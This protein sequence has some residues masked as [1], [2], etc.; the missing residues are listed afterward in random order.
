MFIGGLRGPTEF[1]SNLRNPDRLAR[2]FAEHSKLAPVHSLTPPTVTIRADLS[3]LSHATHESP[4]IRSACKLGEVTDDN[5][6]RACKRVQPSAV[7]PAL[8]IQLPA[9]C[10]PYA[11][12]GSLFG[13]H[14]VTS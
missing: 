12:S 5:R 9:R 3:Y 10:A 6:C 13:R 1:N 8:T 4:R 2:R 14:G 11:S 7:D